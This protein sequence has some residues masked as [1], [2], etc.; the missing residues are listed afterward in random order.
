MATTNANA[1]Q[2]ILDAIGE[3]TDE[4]GTALALLGAAYERLD[5]RTGDELEAGLF[6][7]VQMAYGRGQ[8]THSE[9]AARYDLPRR[10]FEPASQVAP[11]RDARHLIDAAVDA[12]TKADIALASLQD[13]MLPVEFGDPELRAGLTGVREL[14]GELSGRARAIV[15]TV[16]R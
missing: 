8:R 1:R 11:N 15:R 9:F 4:L 14:L 6:R 3:A 10:K 16:G 13:S 12:V 5:E 7:P 2:Q